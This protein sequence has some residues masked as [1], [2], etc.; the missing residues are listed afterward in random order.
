MFD[1]ADVAGSTTCECKGWCWGEEG[2]CCAPGGKECNA[3]PPHRK[4]CRTCVP[5]HNPAQHTNTNCS[6]RRIKACALLL[7]FQKNLTHEFSCCAVQCTPIRTAP[8]IEVI[9]RCEELHIIM[10]NRLVI[11]SLSLSFVAVLDAA[12]NAEHTSQ[13]QQPPAA[14]AVTGLLT[15]VIGSHA[16]AK[17]SLSIT[18]AATPD[19]GDATA[20]ATLTDGP[21]GTIVITG[22]D[23]A[24]LSYGVGWYLRERCNTT[25]TWVKTGGMRGATVRCR[26]VRAC[27]RAC[28]CVCVCMC[29]RITFGLLLSRGCC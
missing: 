10:R 26:Y 4:A 22:S 27:V 13:Q 9:A 3:D 11:L 14:A 29:S 23:L 1:A 25:L 8:V 21:E 24:T 12:N 18:A 20:T 17:F 2:V 28:A 5:H 7:N 6:P 16:A 15:R 19:G